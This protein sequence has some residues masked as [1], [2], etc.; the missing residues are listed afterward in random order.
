MTQQHP[1]ECGT[2]GSTMTEREAVVAWLRSLAGQFVTPPILA[3]FGDP[4]KRDGQL[5]CCE[6]AAAI[7][8]GDHLREHQPR[9][10]EGEI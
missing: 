7:E 5:L 3:F 1:R 4:W 8:A 9:D 2:E 6:L 10:P